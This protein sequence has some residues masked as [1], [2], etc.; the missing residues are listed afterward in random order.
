MPQIQIDKDQ[1]ENTIKRMESDSCKITYSRLSLDK[2]Q[3]TLVYTDPPKKEEPAQQ[4]IETGITPT[5]ENVEPIPK[6]VMN[7]VV[8][9]PINTPDGPK[10]LFTELK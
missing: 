7:K 3:V 8:P 9:K 10:E 4:I 2:K 5:P 1:L 6:P